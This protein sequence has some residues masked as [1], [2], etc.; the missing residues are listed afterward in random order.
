MTTKTEPKELKQKDGGVADSGPSRE[1]STV[2]SLERALEMLTVLGRSRKPLGVAELAR[3]LEVN[4]TT[5]Y[6][7]LNTLLAK[8]FIEKDAGGKYIIGRRTY[9]V[10]RLYRLRFP[11]L[12]ILEQLSRAFVEKWH[13]EIHAGV[14]N[15]DGTVMM[16][17]AQHERVPTLRA[18]DMLPVHAVSMGK[19][20]MAHMPREEAL[21]AMQ[22]SGM[23]SY[24]RNTVIDK[25]SMQ[26]QLREIRHNGYAVDRGEYID[27][28]MCVAAPI[29]DI[30][31]Q[32]V[33]AVSAS[34]S[35]ERM[36]HYFEEILV[37]VFS[38]ARRASRE[39]G[40]GL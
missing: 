29:F 27:N 21:Q 18:N 20:M 35:Q 7:S 26:L 28:V 11:F 40:G 14:Y 5:L 6:A 39:I 25:Q 15:G 13:M 19:A 34:G 8:S 17:I 4:R 38:M 16:L 36:E 24:T 23:K 10:G 37:E 12:D 30:E 32:A 22:L 1:G 2:K 31:G 33:A 3:I 9:E